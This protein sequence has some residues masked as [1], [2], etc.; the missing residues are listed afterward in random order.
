MERARMVDWMI[1]VI[2]VYELSQSTLFLAVGLMDDFSV[3]TK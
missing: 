2:S 3:A 1:E